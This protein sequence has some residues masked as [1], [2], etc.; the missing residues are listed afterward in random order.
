MLISP[1]FKD[2][3]RQLVS[4]YRPVSL[5]CSIAKVLEKLIRDQ[6]LAHTEKH[7]LLAVEQHGFRPG[8]SCLTNLLL[9]REDWVE[10]RD[11]NHLQDVVFTDLSKAFD[12]VSHL[13]LLSK[14]KHFGLD[15]RLCEWF[16]DYLMD[17]RQK[18]RV[19]GVLLGWKAV[20]SGVPQGTALGP[21]LFL[22]Y[23]NEVLKI[24]T[25]SSLLF[26]DD[27]KIWKTVNSSDDRLV[28]QNDLDKLTEWANLWSM[29]INSKKSAV[30]H[31]G[32]K[33]YTSYFMGDRELPDVREETDL[34]IIVS[35]DLK[36]TVNCNRAAAKAF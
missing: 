24:L 34:G 23:V 29:E 9:A 27:I 11:K 17:R 13:G 30:M 8:R 31:L 26:A 14:L 7:G 2:G 33:S 4:N 1:I 19:N 3:N 25:S 5:T 6:F 10:A 28:L 18:V 16:S 12:K 20:L 35:H 22:L 36:T 15:Q 21:L 32:Q